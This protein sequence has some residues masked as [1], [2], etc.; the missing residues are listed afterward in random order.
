MTDDQTGGAPM[1]FA[2]DNEVPIR[3]L[4]DAESDQH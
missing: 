4:F 2:T 3:G 1:T